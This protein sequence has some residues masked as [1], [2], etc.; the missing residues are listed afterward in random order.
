MNY[1]I[2]TL[3]K[4]IPTVGNTYGTLDI[5]GQTFGRYFDYKRETAM[6]AHETQKLKEQT[7]ILLGKIDSELKLSLNSND[8]NFRLEMKRLKILS[9]SIK[10]NK[11]NQKAHLHN[12]SH[13]TQMLGNP[14][15]S[16]EIKASL[17]SLIALE[18]ESLNASLGQSNVV[19]E[20]MSNA[21]TKQIEG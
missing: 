15:I 8:K 20:G 3:K 13:Y 16:N 6:I 5:V 17:P 18:H 7:K 14:H 4:N 12:I 2:E 11:K 21:N 9:K 19:L 1:G 10:S